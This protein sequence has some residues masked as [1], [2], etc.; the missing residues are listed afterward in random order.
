VVRAGISR[1]K[2]AGI[3]HLALRQ[4]GLCRRPGAG[5][6][7]ACHGQYRIVPTGHEHVGVAVHDSPQLF[8]SEYRE[9]RREVEKTEGT[10]AESLKSHLEQSRV[11]FEEFRAA[12]AK[13]PADQRKALILVGASGF[14][15]EEAAAI[16]GCAVGTSSHAPVGPS[17]HRGHGR[18]RPGSWDPRNS[19]GE[20]TRLTMR[21]HLSGSTEE[22]LMGKGILLWLIG[23]PIPIILLL[24]IFGFFH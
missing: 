3:R 5:N 11:E 4:R 21:A 22:H 19:V 15:Y 10:Y 16:C 2:L 8:R 17:F 24:W 18:L 1:A 20:R 14:S 7:A 9:R 13:L 12:L 6:P 23:I